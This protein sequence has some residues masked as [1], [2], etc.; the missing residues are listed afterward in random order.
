MKKI[1]VIED[2]AQFAE[3]IADTLIFNGYI[4]CVAGNGDKGQ[5][6][7]FGYRP[8]LIISDILMPGMNGLELLD[9]IRQDPKY[10]NVPFILL[11]DKNSEKYLANGEGAGASMCLSKS[12]DF[13]ELVLS[14]SR[15]LQQ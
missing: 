14:V 12:C 10:F 13:D 5:Q 3:R 1:L 2:D 15:L 7:L 11:S 9:I 6:S 4:V 8:D